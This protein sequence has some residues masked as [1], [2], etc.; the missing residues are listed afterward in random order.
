MRSNRDYNEEAAENVSGLRSEVRSLKSALT[1][2]KA[3][4]RSIPVEAG[5]KEEALAKDRVEG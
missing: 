5:E 1:G 2:L 3:W 4:L